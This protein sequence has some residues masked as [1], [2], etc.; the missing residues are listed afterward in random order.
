MTLIYFIIA[1]GILIF[2]HEAGHFIMAK[3]A[4]VCVQE[5]S[6]GFGPRLIG[7][8]KG[9]TDYRICL[10]PLGGYVKMLGE[11]PTEE[12]ADNPRSFARKSIWQRALIV[13]FGPVMNVIFAM[14]VMPLVFFI[15]RGQPAYLQEAPVL[16]GVKA[17]SPAALAGLKKG[18][19]IKAIDAKSVDTW[20]EVLNQV[21]IS[22]GATLALTIERDADTLSKNI[23]VD[24]K[25]DTKAGYLGIA[26]MYF[27][28]DGVVVDSV[29]DDGPAAKA[30]LKPNDRIVSVNNQE[31]NNFME[32]SPLVNELGDKKIRLGLIRD[33][34]KIFKTIQPE[35]S[36]ENKRWMIGI[37]MSTQMDMPMQQMRYGLLKSFKYGFLENIKLLKLTFDV[38][39]RLITFQ[40]SYKVLGGPVMIAKASAVA[41]ASGLTHFLYFL[42]FLSMQLAIINLLPI[43]VL[44]GGHLLFL[45]IEKI[46][47]SPVNL[48]VRQTL[49]Q[50]GFILLISLILIIT[51]ND[52]NNLFGIKEW[53]KNLF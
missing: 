42:A 45:G 27:F 49:T 31:I 5:F 4:G 24:K 1:L 40:L 7:F 22:G 11:E 52:V 39:K 19:L 26:P 9:E 51:W 30:G 10:L 34:K 14:L 13:S 25:E 17:E 21:I 12:G 3:R 41:A 44:D 8:K 53:I 36:E 28:G 50:V 20:E 32:F 46:K 38:L 2:V 6:F 18:D 47:K 48:R 29:M 43:P 37:A 16:V 35:Y 15:G 23:K 33:N